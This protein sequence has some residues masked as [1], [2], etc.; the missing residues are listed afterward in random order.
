VLS[1]PI[2]IFDGRVFD[3][4]L[5]YQFLGMGFTTELT[6]KIIFRTFVGGHRRLEANIQFVLVE[7]SIPEEKVVVRGNQEAGRD[8][9]PFLEAVQNS[10]MAVVGVDGEGEVLVGL[11]PEIKL[12]PERKILEDT[13]NRTTVDML[14]DGFEEGVER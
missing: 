9:P 14:L 11:T 4:K 8:D 10:S 5:L 2:Q 7:G 12:D 13:M 6:R 1:D 3:T